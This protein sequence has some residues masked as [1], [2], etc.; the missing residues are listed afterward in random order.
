M[1]L[2]HSFSHLIFFWMFFVSAVL[3]GA[4]KAEF[5]HYPVTYSHG[6][7][8]FEGTLIYHTETVTDAL[9]D[10]ENLPG[11]FMVPNWM[12]PTEAANRK[13]ETIIEE[14]EAVIFVADVYGVEVRPK[15]SGE[16]GEAAGELRGGDREILRRR[17]AA[18]LKAFRESIP[19]H[20]LPVDPKQIMAIGFCFGGGTVL[21]MARDGQDLPGVVSFHGNLGTPRPAEPGKVQAKVLILHGADDPYVPREDVVG[22]QEELRKAGVDW[23]LVSFGGAVHSFTNPRAD[24]DGARYHPVVAERAYEYMEEFMEEILEGEDGWE[25]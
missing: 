10:G 15:N 21:E 23:Q 6:E 2:L 19:E 18:A 3:S 24:S 9:A 5:S 16:A 14:E 13:A 1:K 12:G 4:E 17:A 7:V 11:I 25:D 20:F 8:T 22:V